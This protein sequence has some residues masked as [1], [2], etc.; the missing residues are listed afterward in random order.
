M[1]GQVLELGIHVSRPYS[2]CLE[3]YIAFYRFTPK[4]GLLFS[5]LDSFLSVIR[6]DEKSYYLFQRTYKYMIS[7]GDR[8]LAMPQ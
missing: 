1:Y 7:E 6:K 4:R 3:Q 5:V 8:D 2:I